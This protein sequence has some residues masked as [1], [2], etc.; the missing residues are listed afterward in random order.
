MSSSEEDDVASECSSTLDPMDSPLKYSKSYNLACEKMFS[1]NLGKVEE[2]QAPPGLDHASFVGNVK[3]LRG[4]MKDYCKDDDPAIYTHVICNQYAR[5]AMMTK[6]VWEK[7]KQLRDYYENGKLPRYKGKYVK[8][9]RSSMISMLDEISSSEDEESVQE[10]KG[11]VLVDDVLK[12]LN[13]DKLSDVSR[14]AE[15][16]TQRM[17]LKIKQT[18]VSESSS[19]L[20]EYTT[21][22]Y[23]DSPESRE[24][25]ADAIKMAMLK[26]AQSAQKRGNTNLIG[27][28]APRKKQ[29][30]RSSESSENS[31]QECSTSSSLPRVKTE[32]ESND[33]LAYLGINLGGG[34]GD[35]DRVYWGQIIEE[36]GLDELVANQSNPESLLKDVKMACGSKFCDRKNGWPVPEKGITG[37]RVYTMEHKENMITVANQ[38][39]ELMKA[40][41]ST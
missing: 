25:I 1:V 2:G 20:R 31:S 17:W 3:I 24:F 9:K 29:R 32:P 27:E 41:L 11:K 18:E 22:E 40:R 39:K 26:I 7:H 10:V 5:G 13:I 12:E 8:K 19:G 23:P 33:T 21:Y 35:G 30:I 14:K 15:V 37:Q 36:V 28:E 6:A 16:V 34:G 4:K 38:I